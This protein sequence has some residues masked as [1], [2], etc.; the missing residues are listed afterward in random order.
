VEPF[1]CKTTEER[2]REIV[3]SGKAPD[4]FDVMHLFQQELGNVKLQLSKTIIKSKQ[5]LK[6]HT[7]PEALRPVAKLCC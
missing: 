5:L 7:N 4:Y 1:K 2:I 6:V 3:R